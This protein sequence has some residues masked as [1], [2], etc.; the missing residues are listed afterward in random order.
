[1]FIRLGYDIQFDVPAP[2]AYVAQL[3]VH[4]SRSADL[5][6]PDVLHVESDGVG[7]I[8]THEY[9]DM[10]GNIC[11]RFTAP[12]GHL[13]L[14]N[15][16]LVE[17]SGQLDP[18]ARDAR[19]IPPQQLPDDILRYLLSSRYCEVDLLSSVAVDL[20]GNIAPGWDRVEAI[21]SWVNSKV[22]FNYNFAR[23]TKTALDVFT[24]RVGVCRDFQHL[25]VTFC[26]SMNIPARYVAG[27]LGDIGVP[28][29]GAMDF[30]AWFEAYLDG[31]WWTFDARHNHPRIG[32]VLMAT[33]RDAADVA[34]L[35][36]F[37]GSTLTKFE[38][39]SD[40]VPGP[41]S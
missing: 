28:V 13:R 5:R 4:P 39:V 7:E 35:T 27:Y 30:S 6:E 36:S 40:E 34:F 19:E 18:V 26:R 17:D 3:R 29:N 8:A 25:A 14:W 38:V 23:P 32:R 37:G 10:Y 20:F 41:R 15:S 16:T 33:G 2:L 31:R 1:M 9:S 22:T 12:R 24:E 21:C 11:T